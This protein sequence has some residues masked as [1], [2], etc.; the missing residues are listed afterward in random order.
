MPPALRLT[1]ADYIEINRGT[2]SY[3]TVADHAGLYPTTSTA[4][5]RLASAPLSD[6]PITR[7][8]R[9]LTAGLQGV[10][11]QVTEWDTW[12]AIGRTLRMHGEPELGD[13][14]RALAARG[15]LA[16]GWWDLSEP[17][18]TTLR[19]VSTDLV[20]AEHAQERI[21]GLEAKVATLEAKVAATQRAPR[22]R[23]RAV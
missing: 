1:L 3:K 13:A 12:L 22:Q 11:A 10:G 9:G 23:P 17:R 16:D 18:L 20:T 8:I 4:V 14:G 6:A 5:Q 15:L 7:T 2:A 19:E 21:A